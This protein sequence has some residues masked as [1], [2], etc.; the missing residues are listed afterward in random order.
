M[1]EVINAVYEG[2]GLVRLER[3]PE[4][5]K[6]QERLTVLLVP[7]PAHKEFPVEEVGI[8]GLHQHL[9]EFEARYS[10]ETA[11][12]YTRFVRGEMSDHRDFIVWAGLHELLQRMTAHTQPAATGN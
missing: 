10:L 8:E 1:S 2:S 4:G 12:F 6:P 9:R 5:I 7:V 11:D 3:E